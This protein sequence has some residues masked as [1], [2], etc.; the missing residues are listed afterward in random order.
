MEAEML[1]IARK[2]FMSNTLEEYIAP[3]AHL[4]TP[5]NGQPQEFEEYSHVILER[6]HIF[7]EQYLAA[8]PDLPY[9]RVA[10]FAS[11]LS[12]PSVKASTTSPALKRND[13]QGRSRQPQVPTPKHSAIRQCASA[14]L[15]APLDYLGRLVQGE[16]TK[17]SPI[18][19]TLKHSSLRA[20][21]TC[22]CPGRGVLP[23]N[24]Q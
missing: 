18:A 12:E 6:T 3:F 14:S 15:E 21:H 11:N 5:S 23:K 10:V 20:P 9:L 16:F 1:S 2:V 19:S 4:L 24:R 7:L 13:G 8:Y 17:L 22:R